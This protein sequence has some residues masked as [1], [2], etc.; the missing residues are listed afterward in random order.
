MKHKEMPKGPLVKA[1][2]EIEKDVAD[3][4]KAM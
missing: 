4:I 3:I 1:E 2:Y